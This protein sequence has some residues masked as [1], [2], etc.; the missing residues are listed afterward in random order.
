MSQ[1]VYRDAKA[2]AGRLAVSG[3]VE[4]SDR[5]VQSMRYGSTGT[6]I[7]MDLRAQLLRVKEH[8]LSSG[9]KRSIEVLIDRIDRAI[10]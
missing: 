9:L 7:L 1:D 8:R 2:I 5:I 10:A 3:H 4:D 6:E